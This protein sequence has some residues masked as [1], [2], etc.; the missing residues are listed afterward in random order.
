[1][2][3]R[4]MRVAK[5]EEIASQGARRFVGTGSGGLAVR[6]TVRATVRGRDDIY[7][8]ARPRARTLA[9]A[10]DDR[11]WEPVVWLFDLTATRSNAHWR[12][13]SE[14]IDE[15]APHARD[16]AGM[17]QATH[18]GNA[19]VE[20]IGFCW[21]ASRQRGASYEWAGIATWQPTFFTLRQTSRFMEA[22]GNRLLV[23]R[24]AC[25]PTNDRAQRMTPG[26]PVLEM[27]RHEWRMDIDL[28]D[29]PTSLV[30]MAIPNPF[31]AVTIVAPDAWRLPSAVSA[32]AAA[33]NVRVRL[34][35]HSAFSAETLE[36]IRCWKAVPTVPGSFG[37][38]FSPLA[39]ARF[40]ESASRY[41]ELIPNYW[42][43]FGRGEP[44]PEPLRSGR[45]RP[46]A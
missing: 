42:L 17:R 2:S 30:R 45:R 24:Y 9:A 21:D 33:R 1:M 12:V 29:W 20:Q 11:A 35:R 39:E 6:E 44:E 19:V 4:A 23:A 36:Y 41:S 38:K 15:L 7:I 31:G 14:T 27:F 37:E 40:G 46:D 3:M 43:N 32:E 16:E 10:R 22:T 13:L 26:H 5:E 34:V 25:D 8:R 28:D 18:T